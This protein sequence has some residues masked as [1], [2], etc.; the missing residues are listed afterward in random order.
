MQHTR[1]AYD[2]SGRALDCVGA[3]AEAL[4]RHGMEQ[5]RASLLRAATASKP[6]A[7]WEEIASVGL[8]RLGDVI[9]SNPNGDAG[10]LHVSTVVMLAPPMAISSSEKLGVFISAAHT[11]RE[12]VGVYRIPEDSP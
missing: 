10:P 12:I 1:G 9:V 7:S 11:I 8:A 6:G 2:P 5:A 4:R 3:G